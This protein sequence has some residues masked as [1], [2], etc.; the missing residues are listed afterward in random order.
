MGKRKAEDYYFYLKHSKKKKGFRK[1]SGI[2]PSSRAGCV[3]RS[4]L[5]FLGIVGCSVTSIAGLCPLDAR[6]TT[7][8][9]RFGRYRQVPPEGKMPRA[10]PKALAR[11]T[12]VKRGLGVPV[13]SAFHFTILIIQPVLPASGCSNGKFQTLSLKKREA[14][15]SCSPSPDP[16]NSTSYRG[17]HDW[18]SLC[19]RHVIS[20]N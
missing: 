15:I 7:P 5:G 14:M 4:A 6:S 3:H 16:K 17:G 19:D 18:S 11:H 13:F 1:G 10:G 9:P 12:H 8:P 20:Y 2:W